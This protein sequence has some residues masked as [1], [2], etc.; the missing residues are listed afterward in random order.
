MIPVYPLSFFTFQLPYIIFAIVFSEKWKDQVKKKRQREGVPK[1]VRNNEHIVCLVMLITPKSYDLQLLE[2]VEYELMHRRY[3]IKK[4]KRE[5]KMLKEL[6]TRL[7]KVLL[8]RFTFIN[9]AI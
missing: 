7:S 1:N 3:V 6:K 9:R 2:A 5:T 4:T 8:I